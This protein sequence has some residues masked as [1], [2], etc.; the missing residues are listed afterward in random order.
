MLSGA[1]NRRPEHA[2]TLKKTVQW[3]SELYY[4]FT[5]IK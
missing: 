4:Q 3:I 1:Q 2:H 5:F